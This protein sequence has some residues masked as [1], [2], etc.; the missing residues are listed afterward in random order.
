MADDTNKTEQLN[1]LM[2]QAQQQ[3]QK[4]TTQIEK[5]QE[6][7]SNTQATG[8]AGA[9]AVKVTMNG[10]YEVTSLHISQELHATPEAIAPLVITAVNKAVEKIKKISQKMVAGLA[11]QMQFPGNINELLTSDDES[12]ED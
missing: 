1:T 12:R 7:L 10:R 8:D 9:G 5:A 2:Q 11:G 3:A 4:L 6:E